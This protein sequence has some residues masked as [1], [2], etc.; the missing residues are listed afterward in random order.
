MEDCSHG[1]VKFFVS[2]LPD[3]CSSKE[4]GDLFSRFGEVVG[5]YVARKRDKNGNRFG[6]ISFRG[7]RDKR[8]MEKNM[9]DVKM[10]SFK[11]QVNVARFSLENKEGPRVAENH[12]NS[13]YGPSGG[14]KA[15]N[16]FKPNM[17][18]YPNPLGTAYRDTLVGS[19]KVSNIEEL[20][21]EVS[22]FVKPEEEWPEKSLIVRTVDLKTL[23]ML[24]KLLESV[25]GPKVLI[26]YV[27]G[28]Y[29]L[30][31]FDCSD[32]MERFKNDISGVNDWFSWLEVWKGQTLPFERIAWLKIT[33][34]PLHLMDVEVFDSV[35]RLFGKVVQA[36]SLSKEANDLTF[37]LIGV[38]VGD[39]GRIVKSV[40]LKWKDKKFKVWVEE[41][42]GEWVPGCIFNIDARED[43]GDVCGEMDEED[44]L[45]S[46]SSP[47]G[48]GRSPEQKDT[49]AGSGNTEKNTNGQ[50]GEKLED[51]LGGCMGKN[52]GGNVADQFSMQN[53]DSSN[54]VEIL[55]IFAG[56]NPL[57]FVEPNGF[58]GGPNK[59]GR[60]QRKHS[61]NILKAQHQLFVS[62]TCIPNV[63]KRR[64][65]DDPLVGEA[66][67][68]GSGMEE[69]TV[70]VE[71]NIRT[72]DLNIRAAEI[73]DSHLNKDK[74]MEVK[75]QN[76]LNRKEAA[77][78]DSVS[79]GEG[80]EVIKEAEET[81]SLGREVG[82][83][84]TNHRDLVVDMIRNG[85]FQVGKS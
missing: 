45:F 5:V 51:S 11:L 61:S 72:P 40:T 63:K 28:L 31:I 75:D 84:L 9:K 71:K 14:F 69:V 66:E 53:C 43:K 47:A 54:N 10:G 79:A 18:F 76:Q 13:S 78:V 38:L 21:V 42:L 82:V 41:E 34:V 48:G 62:S 26:K 74:G 7:V 24:D 64:R 55:N 29:L 65:V 56:Y 57:D 33:G 39:G 1:V 6:F 83:D 37:D 12:V 52:G 59:N 15:G 17:P 85:G 22:S 25:G 2:N 68:A 81:I 67:S 46:P 44:G 3:K 35:G 58:V 4:V 80:E 50:E 20:M 49:G 70:P 16:Q 73:I 30:L 77:N 8:E 27:G 32:D 60:A 36:S 23:N 19:S